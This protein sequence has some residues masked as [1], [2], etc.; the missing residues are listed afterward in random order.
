ME[1]TFIGTGAADWKIENRG[2]PDFRRFSSVLVN[3]DLLIDPG[4][5][6]FWYAEDFRCPQVFANVKN[7][8]LT[9]SHED[10]FNMG[11]LE[12]ICRENSAVLWSQ[13]HTLDLKT[14]FAG[15]VQRI[16]APKTPVCVGRYTAT[17]LPANHSTQVPG[18]QAVHYIIEEGDTRIFYGCDGAWLRHD[19]WCYLREFQF[20]LMIF[21]GTLGDGYGDRRIF[22]HNNLRMV[23]LLAEAMRQNDVIKPTGRIMISHMSCFAHEKHEQIVERMKKHK[24]EVAYDG[25]KVII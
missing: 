2:E 18:E 23:E 14:P 5:H 13:M 21:D 10:H 15:L 25:L 16:L 19:T 3:D 17:A 4:P 20:D 12:T 1:L 11:N 8:I 7:C 6:L 22:E 9:H 24:I